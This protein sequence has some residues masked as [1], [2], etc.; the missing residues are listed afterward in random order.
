VVLLIVRDQIVKRES[1]MARDE[2]D[3]LLRIEPLVLVYIR[4]ADQ[5]IGQGMSQTLVTLDKGAHVV[6]EPAVPLLPT[7]ANKLTDLVQAP[8]VPRLG[9]EFDV[10]QDRIGFDVQENG[11][12]GHRPASLVARENRREIKAK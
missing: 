2:I 6:A 12:I 3:A 4:T 1:V 8:G 7:V 11:R 10:R 5:P 9:D